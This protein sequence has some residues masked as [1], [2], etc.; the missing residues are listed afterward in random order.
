MTPRP[1]QALAGRWL[2]LRLPR[3]TIRLRLTLLYGLV[4]VACGAALLAV[5]YL[6]VA[7]QYTDQFFFQNGKATIALKQGSGLESSP[8]VEKLRSAVPVP[9]RILFPGIVVTQAPN[10]SPAQLLAQARLQ[11]DAALHQ[12]LIACGIALAFMALVSVWLGWLV[13]GRALRPLRTITN[14]AREISASDL[15]RRLDLKGPDDELKELGSTFDGLLARLE[16]SF[17]AQRRFVANASHELRTPL[18]LERALIE[19]ALADPGAT[20]ESLRGTLEQVLEASGQQEQLIEALLML[21]RSQRGLDHYDPVN[22]K[23][24]ASDA[25][26]SVA[27]EVVVDADLEPAVT[28]GDPALVGR[29][30]ANLVGNAV[31]HNVPHGWVSVS[32]STRR[33][34]AVL[35]V[36]NS[37]PVVPPDEL[38]RLFQPFQRLDGRRDAE[39]GGLGLGLSIVEAIATAHGAQVIARARPE[40]GLVV[41]VSFRARFR[42]ARPAP[43]LER[44]V[45]PVAR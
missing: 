16:T 37:G 39:R 5:T 25:V 8:A 36:G 40:G 27:D 1:G 33:D 45:P 34:K 17:E 44:P 29:L 18:T 14:A 6:L 22:L 20:S 28:S 31:R 23:E 13:A 30:V 2:G 19:V 43:E 32:T 15:H 35:T 11:S 10:P 12:L 24:V 26:D 42:A 9:P 4:F 21:S 41:E 38:E 7:H 3:R